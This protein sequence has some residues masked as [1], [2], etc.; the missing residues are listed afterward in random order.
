[1]NIPNKEK[2]VIYLDMD[3][4]CTDAILFPQLWNSNHSV[5]DKLSYTLEEV[6]K[7]YNRL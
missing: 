2:P 4:V 1:M 3:G 7:W 6:N 5:K